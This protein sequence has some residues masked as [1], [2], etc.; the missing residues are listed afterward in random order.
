MTREIGLR[1]GAVDLIF[2]WAKN[3]NPAGVAGLWV[4]V[5][6]KGLERPPQ[7]PKKT[8]DSNQGGAECGAPPTLSTITDPDL[9]RVAKAWAD[10]PEPV[11]RGIL[12]MVEAAKGE[13]A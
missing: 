13:G 11:R 5:G 9:A 8:A 12:A 10:L 6:D 7:Y 4:Q 1:A 2:R 3:N